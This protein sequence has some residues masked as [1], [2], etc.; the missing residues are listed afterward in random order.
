MR[1]IRTQ[2]PKSKG[3]RLWLEVLPLETRDPD[4]I[5]AKAL[6]RSSVAS[7]HAD[8]VRRMQE[9]GENEQ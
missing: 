4:V 5:R 7:R 6:D 2:K 3:E 8:P 1:R 9:R